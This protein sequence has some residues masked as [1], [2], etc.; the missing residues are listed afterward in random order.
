LL[1]GF[2][3]VV[4]FHGLYHGKIQGTNHVLENDWLR[5]W[6]GLVAGEFTGTAVPSAFSEV[7]CGSRNSGFGLV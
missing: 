3:F 1:K 4:L 5:A 2:Q 7:L 6:F